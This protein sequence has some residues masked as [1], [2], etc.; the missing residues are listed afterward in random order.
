[1]PRLPRLP[2]LALLL[3]AWSAAPAVER[4]LVEPSDPTPP[5]TEETPYRL[6]D[7]VIPAYGVVFQRPP[8]GDSRIEGLHNE[9][10]A[11][12]A[13]LEAAIADERLHRP[14]D[15][16]E[17]RPPEAGRPPVPVP[18]PRLV[19]PE[20]LPEEIA[21][22]SLFERLVIADEEIAFPNQFERWQFNHCYSAITRAGNNLALGIGDRRYYH[23]REL[24]R[25]WK[26]YYYEL[27][28]QAIFERAEE[29]MEQVASENRQ[30][31]VRRALD[32]ARAEGVEVDYPKMDLDGEYPPVKLPVLHGLQWQPEPIRAAGAGGDG[33]V[34]EATRKATEEKAA[35][36]A[37]RE[38]AEEK[39]RR[40]VDEEAARKAAEEEA[41]RKAAEAEA[42]AAREAAEAEA[43]RAAA[44][45]KAAAEKAAREAAEEKA[46]REAAEE[47]AAR[48]AA[49]AAQEA[50]RKAAEEEARRKAEVEAAE[51][52]ARR[53]A[54]VEAAEEEGSPPP[55]PI[56]FEDF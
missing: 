42:T 53:K 22:A 36:K 33:A 47:E 55:P 4:V 18:M 11:F 16:W 32:R 30:L 2:T 48:K 7:K 54:E 40:E 15:R 23:L 41:A 24:H 28:R 27:I 39:A 49:E 1:M 45:E 9:I 5:P 37:A 10:V 6:V 38:A 13:A 25:A 26:A 17:V 8:R 29:L 31:P 51:E 12:T 21:L 19:E 44:E 14:P 56:D 35:E 50:R 34:D 20:P 52:E 43:A 3:G 46:R